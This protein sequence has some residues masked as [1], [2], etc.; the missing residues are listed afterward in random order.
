MENLTIIERKKVIRKRISTLKSEVDSS[1]KEGASEE[2]LTRVERLQI[3]NDARTIL[4]Y[5]ALPDEVQTASFIDKWSGYKRVLL[6]LVKGEDLILKKYEKGK[7]VPG[8]KGIPEPTEDAETIAPEEVDLAIIP[9]V[10]FDSNCNRL[11]RGKGFY[12]RLVPSLKCKLVGICYDFQIVNE[13]PCED[14]DK[15]MDLVMTQTS[16]FKNYKYKHIIFDVDGTLLDTAKTAMTSLK[17]A[18]KELLGKD[19]EI[20]DLMFYF[21]IPSV[22]T[23][24]I[25]GFEDA[26][27]AIDRWETIYNDYRYLTSPFPGV[28]EMLEQLKKDGL[29]IGI[30]TSR[31]EIE[32]NNDPYL[33]RWDKYIDLLIGSADTVN[34][35]PHPEPILTYME[36]MGATPEECIYIGDTLFDSQCAHGAGL[37]FILTQWTKPADPASTK[38]L[39]E[40]A[41]YIA[42]SVE[43]IMDV[44]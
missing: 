32:I 23:V 37:K 36:R 10:A 11:G 14:F 20:E 34:H 26:D 25:L 29:K 24:K 7:V 6:P 27:Q 2:I 16:T 33:K 13:I 31:N 40:S 30:V 9:G 1:W 38:E 12:D 3:F 41:D 17:L 21:G 8:Y 39:E 28:E 15:R 42:H 5:H 43:D 19:M 44:I 18:I 22:K 4:L 35:K